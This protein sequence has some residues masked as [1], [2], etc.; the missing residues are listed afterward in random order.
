MLSMHTTIHKTVDP[1]NSELKQRIG[2][3][4]HVEQQVRG[5][6]GRAGHA[7]EVELDRQQEQGA[8]HLA[9]VVT[10]AISSPAKAP[11]HRSLAN[12]NHRNRAYG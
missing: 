8:G 10:V 3:G 5:G 2:A 12:V 11:A 6:Y 9:G 1:R 4:D 7:E